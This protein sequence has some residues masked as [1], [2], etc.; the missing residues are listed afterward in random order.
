MAMKRREN[1]LRLRRFRVDELQRRTGT[2][3]AIEADLVRKL[4]DLEETVARERQ[5]AN[6]T[7]LGRLAFPSFL[8]AVDSRRENLK[9]TLNEIERERAQTRSEFAIACQEL[10]SV[11]LAA[12]QDARRAAEAPLQKS[13][14]R[15][16]DIALARQLRKQALRQI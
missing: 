16:G 10:K 9:A 12:E 7:D 15:L 6:D 5:R 4:A 13:R 8:K 1:Q 2:L 14:V 11:E 3:D